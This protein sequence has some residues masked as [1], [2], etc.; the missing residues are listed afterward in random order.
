MPHPGGGHPHRPGGGGFSP[1]FRRGGGG[2]GGWWPNYYG[3]GPDVVVMQP[4]MNDCQFT[5]QM[6]SGERVIVTGVC[7]MPIYGPVTA[8]IR[9]L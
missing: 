6:P 2:G 1:G 8:T 9:P 4:P 7:P 5:I 3:Y